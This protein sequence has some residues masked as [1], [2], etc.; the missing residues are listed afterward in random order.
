MTRKPAKLRRRDRRAKRR[1]TEAEAAWRGFESSRTRRTSVDRHLA[2]GCL[3]TD[4]LHQIA[5]LPR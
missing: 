4:L 3:T 5:T 1:A 2:R